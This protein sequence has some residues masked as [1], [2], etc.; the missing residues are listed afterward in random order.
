MFSL[1]WKNLLTNCASKRQFKTIHWNTL[2]IKIVIS[3]AE[4]PKRTLSILK[5]ILLEA[6]E[7]H[8]LVSQI[9][10]FSQEKFSS[11]GLVQILL[12]GLLLT[13]DA[14]KNNLET[15]SSGLAADADAHTRTWVSEFG[16]ENGKKTKRNENE[17]L[18]PTTMRDI[19]R[20]SC[21]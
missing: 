16:R 8:D 11:K 18:S 3:E 4:N 7:C 9:R 17:K 2:S 19:K 10:Y 21:T 6:I 12:R 15:N 20:G 14:N 1:V 13:D 5:L